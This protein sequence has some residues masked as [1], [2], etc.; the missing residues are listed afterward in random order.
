L[1]KDTF[2][3]SDPLFLPLINHFAVGIIR[4]DES[5]CTL[6]ISLRALRYAL[7]EPI[8]SP[9][10]GHIANK[11]AARQKNKCPPVITF[12][13]LTSFKPFPYSYFVAKM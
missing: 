5:I 12:F 3:L 13:S 7:C 10:H 2:R 8:K 4:G 1:G 11:G 6:I 9:V